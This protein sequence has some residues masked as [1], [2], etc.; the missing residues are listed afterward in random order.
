MNAKVRSIDAPHSHC[1]PNSPS[2]R[3]F[4]KSIPQVKKSACV[5]AAVL[6]KTDCS[7]C[8]SEG[9]RAKQ[10]VMLFIKAA[11][12]RAQ[13]STRTRPGESLHRRNLSGG[14]S[15]L[16][17][18]KTLQVCHGASEHGL[19]TGQPACS[20]ISADSGNSSPAVIGQSVGILVGKPRGCFAPK[21]SL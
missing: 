21:C 10:P 19:G 14:R 4:G 17:E 12:P 6:F 13:R 16:G 2:S 15:Q 1:K 11:A 20:D 5:P 18:M 9:S 7:P 3:A 8:L